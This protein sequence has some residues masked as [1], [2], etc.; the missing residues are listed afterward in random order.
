M[1]NNIN[2]YFEYIRYCVDD[3]LPIPVSIYN[4][5]W[6]DLYTF[7]RQQALAGVGFLGIERLRNE[8]V[9]IPKKIF[10]K[11]YALSEKIRIR[12]VRVNECCVRLT[13]RLK[14]DGFYSCILK[15]QGNALLYSNPYAR[16]PGDI[17]IFVMKTEGASIKE[18]RKAIIEYARKI[19]PQTKMRYQHIEF[20][21]FKA[22][23]VEMHFIPTA[24]NNPVHN[25]RIQRWAEN[26]MFKQC[27]NVVCLPDNVGTISVPT[28]S[29]NLIYQL[30][31]LMHH[32]FD[33]GIGLRQMMDY[34]FVLKQQKFA[35]NTE[36]DS[37]SFNRENGD[38]SSTIH[39]GTLQKKLKYL[40]LYDFAGAVM[41]VMREVFELEEERMIVPIDVERGEILMA[42]IMKGGN[43]GKY[44]G[45]TNHST[46]TKYF[47][48]I[49][50]NLLF[51]H[52][53]PAEALCEP[54]FRTWHFFWRLWNK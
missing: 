36:K 5:D 21:V 46:G 31:H 9:D 1:T 3:S 28:H 7:M 23:S 20:P 54:I 15:G 40:G 43:F 10:T 8:G 35:T 48:K 49:K 2:P 18:R 11:W 41:Y 19:F 50:R 33:E 14:K 34:Y 32:F 45:L 39:I 24:K 22:I 37:S 51:V 53:Y 12:N 16:T 52:K 27:H 47:L 4:V 38:I 26:R 30:S 29:F 13:E 17:D 25:R 6:D 42:E 44:S